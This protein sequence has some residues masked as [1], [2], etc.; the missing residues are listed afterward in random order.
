[1]YESTM[2]QLFNLYPLVS[3][4]GFV[5]VDDWTVQ[6]CRAAMD[7]FFKWHDLELTLVTIDSSS[8]YWQKTSNP[9]LKMEKY[10]QLLAK[11]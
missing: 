10:L 1:M 4:G 8:I 7:D 3:I 2:D 9:V 5:I 6:P 11:H